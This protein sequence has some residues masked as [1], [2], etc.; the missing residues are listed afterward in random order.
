MWGAIEKIYLNVPFPE[1]DKAKALGARWDA[2]AKKWYYI[3]PNDV[4]AA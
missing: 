4:H 1:K 2:N 3:N